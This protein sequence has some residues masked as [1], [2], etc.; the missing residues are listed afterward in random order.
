VALPVALPVSS[1]GA[2]PVPAATFA[3]VD[4]GGV[5]RWT[6]RATAVRP[7]LETPASRRWAWALVGCCVVVVIALGALFAHQTTADGFDRVLDD[8]VINSLGRNRTL[9]GW[10]SWPG[11]QVPA[12]V[13]SLA[14]ALGCLR[15]R[16]LNG[17]VLALTAVFIA[18]RLDDAL[19]K[20]LVDR[21]YL[22]A[23]S[24]PSGH[25]SSVVALCATYVVLFVLPV[26]SPDRPRSNTGRRWRLVGL[27]VLLLLVVSTVLGVI[28]LRWHYFTDTVAGAAVAVA[29]VGAL[30]LLLDAVLDGFRRWPAARRDR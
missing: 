14:M 22:G 1:G 16:R 7:L 17:V 4:Y 30:C 25:T 20:T 23:L 21:T 15:A 9:A 2:H 12:L 26:A 27:E 6:R 18:T 28:G 29:V 11:T 8:P 13:I 19:L 3:Y 10:M 5:R 24:Y